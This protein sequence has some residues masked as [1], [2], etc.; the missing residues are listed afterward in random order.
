MRI[1]TVLLKVVSRCNLDCS[2]CYVYNMGDE[3]WRSMPKRML[4]A[5]QALVAQQLGRL[6]IEQDGPF[7][8]VLHGGEPL[9]LGTKGLRS[10]LES[11]RDA[12]PASC[13]VAI[14]T[15]GVLL[16]EA[17]LD[18]CAGFGV[19]LS[20]SLDGPAAVHDKHRVDRGGR[21]S[22]TRVVAGLSK[23]RAHPKAHELFSGVLAV[24]DPDS[25]PEQV[26][27]YFRGL[28]VPSVD[29]LYRDGNRAKLPYG[30]AGLESTEYGRWMAV[31][32][33]RYM[34]D[35]NP[36]RIRV[37]DDLIKL[38][39]G[40]AGA[41][42]GV[43]ITDFGILIIDTDGSITK[44]DTL[45]STPSGDR[46]DSNWTVEANDLNRIVQSREFLTYHKMQR[47][48]S[49]ICKACPEL[50]VCGGGMLSHRYDGDTGYDNPTVFCS[51]Q[52]LLIGRLRRYLAAHAS[53]RAAA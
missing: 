28:Q 8:V 34:T 7:A 39:L 41:K 47:P 20:V 30:K 3:S 33:H 10:L 13:T 5:T 40:G 25:D 29:F 46:F 6:A 31:V 1:D 12:L 26:Y 45:K 49:S 4:P 14:Q 23:L 9:L 36:P 42:E 38:V 53:T 27:D 11:L 50:S 2:Y 51:D 37:L 21:A 44:N 17:L 43:G 52:K 15:N 35:T 16:N 32:L 48:S 19:S 18:L 22:H 24:V